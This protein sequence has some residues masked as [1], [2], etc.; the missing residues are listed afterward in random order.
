MLT[1]FLKIAAQCEPK[2][3][4][5]VSAKEN[6][7]VA[8]SA[9]GDPDAAVR[10]LQPVSSRQPVLRRAHSGLSLSDS[11]ILRHSSVIIGLN[12]LFVL[13]LAAKVGGASKTATHPLGH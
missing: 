6:H 9:A 10:S 4:V 5:A 2:H 11:A 7:K 13:V 12:A 3:N 1:K 8:M